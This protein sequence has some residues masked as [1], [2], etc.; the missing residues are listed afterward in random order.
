ME[1]KP[2][3]AVIVPG[4]FGEDDYIPVLLD[5]LC[6]L[7]ETYR[8]SIYSFSIAKIHP[9]LAA[10]GCAVSCPPKVIEGSSFLKGLYHLWRIGRDSVRTRFT[11][12]HGFWAMPQGATAVLAGKLFGIP[13]IVSV[14]GGDVVY[15]PSIAYGG[16][17]SPLHRILVRW[18]I[19]AANRVT[20]LT[21]YQRQIM[22]KDRL[23]AALISVIPFGV[24]TSRF[25]FQSNKIPAAPKL[26]FIGSINSVKDPYTLISTFSHLLKSVDCTLTIAGPDIIHGRAQEYAK[27][28][29]VFHKIQW[30]GQIHHESIPALLHSLDFLLL[31]SRYEGEGVVVMEAFA[32]GTLVAG[33]NVGL[34]AD[35]GDESITADPGDARGL[36]EKVLRLIRDPA[37]AH[38]MRKRNRA[39]AEEWGMDRTFKEFS[40][41]YDDALGLK[42]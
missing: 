8:V 22:D 9:R 21:R 36:A 12:I 23:S 37:K 34:L 18:V 35:V 4:G 32:S 16:T 6:R 24:D 19:G 1:T 38:E 20:V 11:L 40:A 3:I 41:I 5:L 15:L 42:R 30:L 13:A 27:S 25:A 17:R 10:I 28:L 7:G 39:I 29:G 33:S 26:G 14:M 31:T 2:C